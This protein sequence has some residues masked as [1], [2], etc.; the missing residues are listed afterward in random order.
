MV[1]RIHEYEYETYE[2]IV[3]LLESSYNEAN[4][5]NYASIS[6]KKISRYQKTGNFHH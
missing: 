3:E 4:L 2:L 1:K 5:Y 6:S